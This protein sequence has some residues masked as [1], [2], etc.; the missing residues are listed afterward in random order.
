MND[1]STSGKSLSLRAQCLPCARA[2]AAHTVLLS[3][4]R[5]I[6][7]TLHHLLPQMRRLRHKESK[8]HR[9]AETWWRQD[10]NRSPCLSPG[11]YLPVKCQRQAC[12]VGDEEIL[13]RKVTHSRVTRR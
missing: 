7:R 11:I 5:R 3:L 4:T 13:G 6:Q 1:M 12:R 10:L 9:A 8:E 2:Q